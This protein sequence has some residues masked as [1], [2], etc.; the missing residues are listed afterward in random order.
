MSGKTN[1]LPSDEELNDYLAA[2]FTDK[3]NQPVVKKAKQLL[4]ELVDVIGEE[5]D[6]PK[7]KIIESFEYRAKIT[8]AEGTT[9]VDDELLA[10]LLDTVTFKAC[11]ERVFSKA[12]F[13]ELVKSGRI[14][15]TIAEQVLKQKPDV[16]K[17]S[18]EK[19]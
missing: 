10:K 4:K 18:V 13:E 9:Y 12:K 19:I 2:L 16:Q 7:T 15:A 17:I 11:Q 3:E 1:K 14:N 6:S 5:T 8:S